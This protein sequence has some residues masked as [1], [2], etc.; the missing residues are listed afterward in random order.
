MSAVLALQGLTETTKSP[1][2]PGYTGIGSM[3]SIFSSCSS[4]CTAL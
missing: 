2:T 3:I 1:E 4:H